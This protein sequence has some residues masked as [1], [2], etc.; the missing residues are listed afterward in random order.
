MKDS[1][2]CSFFSITELGMDTQ[3]SPD[4]RRKNSPLR[5]I[6]LFDPSTIVDQEV[7]DRGTDL[8]GGAEPDETEGFEPD[9]RGNWMGSLRGISTSGA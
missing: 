3:I 7:F 4:S 1:H 9:S 2:R 5:F 8:E 6:F